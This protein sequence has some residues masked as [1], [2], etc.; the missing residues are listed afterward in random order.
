MRFPV[1][2]LVILVTTTLMLAA[3]QAASANAYS[4]YGCQSPFHTSAPMDAWHVSLATYGHASTDYWTNSCPKQPVYMWMAASTTHPNGDN[5]TETFI[6]PPNT[7]IQSY[8]IYR[9][10]RL[11]SSGGY[12][13][14]ARVMAAG[15]WYLVDG[16][17]G[18]AGCKPVGTT[19]SAFAKSNRLA[20]AAPAGTTQVQL[21]VV[22][23]RSG[24]CLKEPGGVSASVWL[25]QSQITLA[26]A[27]APQFAAAP[28]GPLVSG[29]P[30]A[31]VV[32]VTIAATDRGGGVNQAIIMVD[33]HVLTSQVLASNGGR[34]ALPFLYSVPCALGAN[35]TAYL[36]TR[37]LADGVH[38][39]TLYVSDAA[40][41]LA[42]W[43]PFSIR[44][45]NNPCSPF[46]AIG[47][48][49]MNSAFVVVGHKRI[50]VHR[51]VRVITQVHYPG[52]LLRNYQ[53]RPLAIGRLTTTAGQPIAHVPV[54]IAAINNVA[55][56]V[57]RPV[58]S[59]ITGNDGS[60]SH[61]LAPGPSR[62]LVFIYRA[63]GGAISSTV[64]ITVRVPVKVHINK[65][66]LHNRQVMTW[67][68]RVPGPVPQGL[69]GLMQVWR[70]TFWQTFGQP[71]HI[72][73][74]GNWVGRYQFFFTT[75]RQDYKFRMSVPRQSG[76][77]YAGNVSAP[78]RVF[79]TG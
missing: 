25:F 65:H 22:C 38:T 31:G 11:V 52:H 77:P 70:G 63:P 47:G 79:V 24:G 17:G 76:Y 21:R 75:G 68:G 71:I 34:C 28:S 10:V 5:A 67:W 57:L 14:Q 56:S 73:P 1:R 23:G 42:A 3:A 20:H 66:H 39:V 64:S 37:T 8:S 60:F 16:C 12:Y 40:G 51:R 26:D 50:R 29:A 58:G 46:P 59:A 30:L 4:V 6:A 48:M 19:S 78:L 36:D 27:Y 15:H 45:I 69:L 33:G 53:D 74:N 55:G 54:C 44:T 49:S 62:T 41:N 32:P 7:T 72:A 43:G 13:Y 2:P 61:R 18:A 9:A 35:G